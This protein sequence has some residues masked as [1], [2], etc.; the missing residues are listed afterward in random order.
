MALRAVRLLRRFVPAR[1][2]LST[3][4]SLRHER[5]HEV[6]PP[7]ESFARRHIGPSAEDA[8]EMLKTCGVEVRERK[9]KGDVAERSLK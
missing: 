7:L 5:L 1:R 2:A 4:L 9:R 3:T 6:L 8:Q